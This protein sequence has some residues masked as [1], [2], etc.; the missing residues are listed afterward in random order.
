MKTMMAAVLLTL[1]S[2]A[3]GC[4]GST[5]PPNA[6]SEP[7]ASTAS[8]GSTEASAMAPDKEKGLAHLREHVKY[9][10][11]RK[12]I[13]AACADTPEFTAGEK[14]WFADHL[15]EGTYTSAEDVIKAVGW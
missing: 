6:P 5:P 14:K 7:A 8:T 11:D 9:P 12:T 13:L 3:V 2:M 15:P 1:A 4:G 10:A